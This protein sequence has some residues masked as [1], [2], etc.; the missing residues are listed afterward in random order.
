LENLLPGLSFV[1]PYWWSRLL[2]RPIGSMEG[3]YWSLYVEFK[4]YVFAAVIYY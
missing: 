2:G 4:F 1:E 3:A